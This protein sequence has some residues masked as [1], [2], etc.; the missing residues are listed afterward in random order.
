MLSEE[1]GGK[2]GIELEWWEVFGKVLAWEL[3]WP[4]GR[5]DDGRASTAAF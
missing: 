5:G 2:G 1:G 3:H 4:F